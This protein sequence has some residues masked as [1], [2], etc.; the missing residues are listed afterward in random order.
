MQKGQKLDDGVLVVFN[1]SRT[2]FRVLVPTKNKKGNE[3]MRAVSKGEVTRLTKFDGSWGGKTTYNTNLTRLGRQRAIQNSVENQFGAIHFGNQKIR[4]KFS[5]GARSF[6]ARY[7]NK[8][9]FEMIVKGRVNG[10][11]TVTVDSNEPNLNP[12]RERAN[13]RQASRRRRSE[14]RPGLA[15]DFGADKP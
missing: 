10:E 7:K 2:R 1:N 12:P 9:G 15:R 3:V 13:R 14:E 11:G 6:T 4:I 8:E 5:D